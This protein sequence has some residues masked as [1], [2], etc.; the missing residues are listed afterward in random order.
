MNN[1]AINLDVQILLFKILLSSLLGIFP[2]VELLINLTVILFSYFWGTILFSTAAV[3]FNIPTNSAQGFQFLHILAYTCHF[4][5]FNTV[6]LMH[7]RWYLIVDL[8]CIFLMITTAEHLFMLL[9][10]CVCWRVYYKVFC[11]FLNQS[12]LITVFRSS[13]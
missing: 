13:L 11:P 9:I 4:V 3:S 6:I 8:I 1:A 12:S 2:E 5:V 7:V 10:M